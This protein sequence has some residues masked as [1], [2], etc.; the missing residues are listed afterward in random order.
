MAQRDYVSRGRSTQKKK[1]AGKGRK[2]AGNAQKN[3][4][5]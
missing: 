1:P 2:P 4:P 5:V 3:A